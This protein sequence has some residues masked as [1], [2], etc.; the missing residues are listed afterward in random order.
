[1][2]LLL[3]L[4]FAAHPRP[5]PAM[6]AGLPAHA[7]KPPIAA[8][9]ATQFETVN[10]PVQTFLDRLMLAESS[11]QLDARNPR[12][13]ALGPFQFIESTFLEVAA[14]PPGR[15]NRAVVC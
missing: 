13:T 7:E 8:S 3:L 6:D 15:N 9:P 5:V 14:G 10:L 4:V 1:L 11:G 12:S 2:L